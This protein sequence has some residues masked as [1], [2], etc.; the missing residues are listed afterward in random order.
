MS[1]FYLLII[2]VLLIYMIYLKEKEK[3]TIK[4]EKNT[5]DDSLLEMVGKN[6]EITLKK[7]LVYIDGDYSLRGVIKEMDQDW[8]V[9]ETTKKEK[10]KVRVIRKSI[11]SSIKMI[12]EKS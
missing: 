3:K 10:T 8:L 12:N 5:I 6:C 4:E 11:V 9:I 1:D 2:V 7:M